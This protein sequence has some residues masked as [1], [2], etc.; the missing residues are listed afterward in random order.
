MS[1]HRICGERGRNEAPPP[2][3]ASSMACAISPLPDIAMQTCSPL[4][5]LV[6][7]CRLRY[8]YTI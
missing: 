4:L 8:E 1:S 7:K 5:E 2:R 3:R 6:D